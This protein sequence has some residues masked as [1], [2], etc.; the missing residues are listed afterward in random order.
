MQKL[1]AIIVDDEAKNI[2]ALQALIQLYC[3]QIN[4]VATAQNIGDAEILIRQHNPQIV[5]L[6]V[7]M[8]MGNGFELLEKFDTID[9][10]T[11]FITAFNHYAVQAFKFSAIDYLLKPADTDELINAVDKAQ[12]KIVQSNINARVQTLLTNIKTKNLGRKKISIYTMDTILF[13]EIDDIMHLQS[14]GNYTHIFLRNNKKETVS[15]PIKEFEDLLPETIFCRIHHSHIININ[16][17]KKYHKG[18]G[19]YVEM[20]DNTSI[21]VSSRKRDSFLEMLK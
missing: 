5:F 18:R 11:I 19:G 21:E 14:D 17:I 7:E 16:Y 15:K 1:I 9:F 20:D 6:D 12:E 4:V 13:E 3:K 10:E 8:P 2:K